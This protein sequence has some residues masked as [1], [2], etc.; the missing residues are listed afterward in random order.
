VYIY[1][2]LL[3]G[4]AIYM[5]TNSNRKKKL[6]AAK[7]QAIEPGVHV[8]TTFGLYGTVRGT[9]DDSVL[10]EIDDNVLVRISK[11]AVGTVVPHPSDLIDASEIDG[12]HPGAEV[13]DGE[14][15]HEHGDDHDHGHSDELADVGKD[16]L[17]VT[18]TTETTTDK[19]ADTP[20]ADVDPATAKPATGHDEG[21]G[22]V[23]IR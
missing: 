4:I 16:D 1:V 5:F 18:D 15:G 23:P 19:I 21:P 14:P 20:V 6:A 13:T 8:M 7:Q 11:R 17:E 3:I 12:E 9:D 10:L 2:I 22:P